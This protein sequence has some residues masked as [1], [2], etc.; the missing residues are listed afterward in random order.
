MSVV[1]DILDYIRSGEA[2]DKNLGLEIEHFVVNDQGEQITFDE[3]TKL[4]ESVAK[5][6][7][8]KIHHMDGY[9]VGY[10]T[11]EYSVS[12]EPACQFEISIDPFDDLD[13]I[14]NIYDGFIA[15]WEPLF[16]ERGYHFET[17]GNLPL[18][19]LGKIKP[20]DIPLSAKKR[21]KYI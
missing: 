4:I 3:V 6:I 19:E 21:Y 9:P 10:Y 14:K 11:G 13:K 7:G 8:A 20:D 15:L 2:D 18:V 16:N 5:R 12:L 17:K 1:D